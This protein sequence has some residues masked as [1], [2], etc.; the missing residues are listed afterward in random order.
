MLCWS[1][2]PLADC[3]NHIKLTG[4]VDPLQMPRVAE[5]LAELLVVP[6]RS[7]ASRNTLTAAPRD[8]DNAEFALVTLPDGIEYRLNQQFIEQVAQLA[9][10]FDLDELATAQMLCLAEET[11]FKTGTSLT[12]AGRIAF[13]TRYQ[14]ILNIVGYLV[15]LGSSQFLAKDLFAKVMASFDK[16][17]AL[18]NN[19]HTVVEKQALTANID[20][21]TFV[22]SVNYSKQQ[23][24]GLHASLAQILFGIFGQVDNCTAENY[25]RLA[26]HITKHIADNDSLILHYLPL[27]LRLVTTAMESDN[28]NLVAQLHS[29]F[30]DV[31]TKDHASAYTNETLDATKSKL[32]PF[33][34]VVAALF[35]TFFTSWCKQAASRTERY[36]YRDDVLRY[37]EWLIDYEMMDKL[38]S[39][40]AESCNSN[41]ANF[42]WTN[43]YDFRAL[44]QRTSPRLVPAKFA[45]VL[46]GLNGGNDSR[47][48]QSENVRLLLDT[49]AYNVRTEFKEE[50]LAPYLHQFFVEFVANS[51]L[52][53]ILL[54]DSEEDFLLS[55][56]GKDAVVDD[57]ERHRKALDDFAVHHKNL[58]ELA[59][60]LDLE[61]FYL[62]CAYTYNNRPEL[63]SLFWASEYMSLDFAGFFSW[64]LSN[65][66]SPLI[67]ATFCLALGALALAGSEASE[68]IWDMLAKSDGAKGDY[69]KISIDTIT[70]S[71]HYYLDS[72]LESFEDDLNKRVK[73]H[74]K[75]QEFM[76]TNKPDG[77]DTDERIVIELSEDSVVFILG[78]MQL[79]SLIVRNLGERSER[80]ERFERSLQIKKIAFSRF[81]PIITG[82]LRFDNL[83]TGSG[84]NLS[85]D[86]SAGQG[87]PQLIDLPNVLVDPE[88]RIVLVNLMLAMMNDFVADVRTPLT[89]RYETWRVLDRWMYQS[90][91][92]TAS[93]NDKDDKDLML[94]PQH[95]NRPRYSTK[96]TV[97]IAEAFLL[98]LTDLSQVTNFV[99]LLA[100][101]LGENKEKEHNGYQ[102]EQ[103]DK[104]DGNR[105]QIEKTDDNGQKS[106]KSQ[107]VHTLAYPADLGQLYRA[108]VGVWP[109][110]EYLMVTIFGKTHA[111]PSEADR[112]G[113][114]LQIL[115]IVL[116]SLREV[117]WVYLDQTA[118]RVRRGAEPNDKFLVKGS[119]AGPGVG[120][121][122]LD[123]VAF[124]RL[125]Q[126][127]AFMSYLFDERVHRS[128]FGILGLGNEA[129]GR[130]ERVALLVCTALEVVLSVLRVEK[131]FI[132]CLVPICRD[133]KDEQKSVTS[134]ALDVY[135]PKLVGTHGFADFCEVLLFNLPVVSHFALYVG[136]ADT[137][138]AVAA[139]DVL[140]HIVESKYFTAKSDGVLNRNRLLTTFESVNESRTI[141]YAFIEQFENRGLALE[142]KYKILEFLIRDLTDVRGPEVAHF[143]LGYEIR[144]GNLHCVDDAH[145]NL[146]MKALLATLDVGMGL[147]SEIDYTNGNVHLID[148]GPAKLSAMILDILTK[149]CSSPLSSTITLSYLRDRGNFFEKLIKYQPKIDV[150][151]LWSGNVFDGDLSEDTNNRFVVSSASVDT[152]FS[153]LRQ[154]NL[155]LQYLS[156]EFHN[157][158]S[159]SKKDY[160]VQLLLNSEDFLD[161]SPKIL[162]FLDVLNFNFHNF[163]VHLFEPL[164]RRYDLQYI[165]EQVKIQGPQF[166]STLELGEDYER[167]GEFVAKYLTSTGLREIQ[168]ACLHSWCQ[169]IEILITDTSVNLKLF[170]LQVLQVILPK[171]ND[172]LELDILFSEELISLAVLL[173]DLYDQEILAERQSDEDFVLGIERLLPLLKTCVVGILNSNSTPSLRSDLY[174]LA[175][176]FLL[177]VFDRANAPAKENSKPP[178]SSQNL[179]TTVVGILSSVDRKLAETVCNDSIYSEGA[180]RITSILLLESLIH[181]SPKD[182]LDVLVKN[183]Y[184]LLLVRS[185]KRTDE[186]LLI[187][188]G[189]AAKAGVSLELL[190]YELTAFKLTLY[191]L[192]RVAQ[193]KAGAL[194]LIQCE[195]FSILKYS[196]FLKINPDLGMNL[197]IEEQP[198]KKSFRINLVL[199]TPLA[200]NDITGAPRAHS[201]SDISYYEFLVPIFQL[202]STLVLSMG[203]S[204]KPSILQAR[205]LLRSVN[206]LV[207]GVM[208]RDVLV[209]QYDVGKNVY[210]GENYAAVGLK[211]LLK[212]FVLLD[213][214]TEERSVH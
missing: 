161:G 44:L 13:Y 204:Y 209:E 50:M 82:F 63:C 86:V 10:E 176:K 205:E 67:T 72:L 78:F 110:V 9:S 135:I 59:V 7:E 171:V 45:S 193:L 66:T 55:S 188:S 197:R 26:A 127:V 49:T 60:R 102:K 172:Y 6:P 121:V 64:S 148:M 208:K 113:L 154:R 24:F 20:D 133:R 107:Y 93:S 162:N 19:I 62:A 4:S 90:L 117:D 134:A 166:L 167:I 11:Q 52:V 190:L 128:L 118:T 32:R 137:S 1:N 38:L 81:L 173:F 98:N 103:N 97:R 126:L 12:D 28:D 129:V 206:P 104:G 177:K 180:S 22:Q 151:S 74:Q 46:E 153:F 183:N 51:A 35:F 201:E 119:D 194:Q 42:D 88:N 140:G 3:Y 91:P 124:V 139:L 71:L 83:V 157:I 125:H 123:F 96:R 2:E 155:T 85:V 131:T 211:E 163:E 138:I 178:A 18:L 61:R 142:V 122:Y 23:I 30:T 149:L 68:R 150:H 120:D 165:V 14:Y 79:V 152:F 111:M 189:D 29:H 95:A 31:L 160:Y 99:N 58:D 144:G 170:I 57:D 37:I 179:R 77:A 182:V 187:C 192:I 27:A 136:N 156:L 69:S 199:D 115:T 15:S 84:T 94:F 109:Y 207:V 210:S 80:G 8:P 108:Q 214:L 141:K 105:N 175:N 21:L 92:A 112:H 100:S 174:V 56:Y 143:L 198:E 87:K 213:L 169:L 16:L 34:V 212:L 164:N 5:D 25:K 114:Q 54:R 47:N 40:A 70:D 101:L 76:F 203:P 185:I 106:V 196:N 181:I 145:E 43:L 158:T 53:L 195:L 202:V 159:V 146:L 73:V 39:M 75:R 132:G 65:N 130:N 116:R 33:E 17:Y 184:L 200:L 147:I 168:L 191:F 89:M 36:N 41:T 186:M 48:V